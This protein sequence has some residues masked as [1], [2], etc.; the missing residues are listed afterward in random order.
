MSGIGSSPTIL[1]CGG[2][3]DL[4]RR[5]AARLA[6]SGAELRALVRP[7]T[8]DAGLRDLGFRVVNGDLRDADSLGPAVDGIHT[9]VSTASSIGRA[10]SG[11]RGLRIRDVDVDG[12]AWL[13][14]AAERA[15]VERFVYLSAALPPIAAKLAPYAAAKAATE[16]R[17]RRSDLRPV[18]VRPDM[19]QELW[20]SPETQFDWP[21]GKLTIFGRGDAKARYVAA[22]DVA[23]LTVSLALAEDPPEVVEFGGP[24]ALTRNEAADLF[25]RECARP[26]RR[27]HVPRGALRV[28]VAMLR[29]PKPTLA[30]VMGMALAADLAD[31]PWDDGPLVAAGIRPRSTTEFVRSVVHGPVAGQ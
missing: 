10:M 7:A 12:Y 30:S 19:F 22:G 3:G 5:I 4:G 6:G 24:E 11:E 27:R 21:N 8:S 15:G 17:L 28:G 31:S 20:L 9:I 13:I 2:T 16:Q 1:L 26:M 25:E 18:I 29:R 23:A 14:A